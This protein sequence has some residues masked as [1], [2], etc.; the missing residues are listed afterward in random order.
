MDNIWELKEYDHLMAEE[1]SQNLGISMAIAILLTQR[2]IK[3]TNEAEKFLNGELEDLSDPFAITGI[4]AAVQRIEKAIIAAEK[5]VIYGDYDVDGICSTVLL[6][7]CLTELGGQVDYYVPNRFSEGYGLNS[8]AVEYLA[9]QGYDLLVTVD[10]GIAS[11]TETE[12]ANH[13]GMDVIITDHHTPLDLLPMAIAVINPKLD[14]LPDNINLAGVGVAFALVRAL[15]YG[16]ISDERVFAWLDLVALATV[17]DIVPMLGDNRILVKYGLKNLQKTSRVGLRA[18]ITETG[19]DGKPL[20]SWH[21]GFILAPRLNAAG[22]LDNAGISIEL[23][24]CD[25]PQKAGEIAVMLCNLNNERRTIEEAIFKEAVLQVETVGNLE[26]QPVLVLAG[27]GWHQG[28]IGIVASRLADRYNRPIILISWEGNT[29]KG[30]GRSTGD[31]DLYQAL[32]LCRESLLQFGGH[33]M[34]AGLS[35]EKSQ[36][37]NFK[38]MMCELGKSII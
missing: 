16:K 30:S 2:G 38:A 7:E 9:E 25:D 8:T 22:R 27:E 4:T 37:A 35:I 34:A 11:I 12:L 19:L 18:L 29:G 23:L 33:R 15:C 17:A 10:C 26:D 36:F 13:L 20:L 24:L 6:K 14:N 1:I 31:F 5:V 21:I 3:S 32:H 28:V